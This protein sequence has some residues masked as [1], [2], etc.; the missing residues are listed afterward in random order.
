MELVAFKSSLPRCTESVI[1]FF[2]YASSLTLSMDFIEMPLRIF[3]LEF[4]A[5]SKT[6]INNSMLFALHAAQVLAN[7]NTS[8]PVN[9]ELVTDL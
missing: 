3:S 6:S 2:F 4:I 8:V 9:Y 7:L 1:F 5:K